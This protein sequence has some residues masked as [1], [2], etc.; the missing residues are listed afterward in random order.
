MLVLGIET[1]CD[2]TAASV[3]RNGNEIL[4]NVVSS[5]LKYHKKFGGVIPEIA[6]RH[7]AENIDKVILESLS[8]A[9]IGFKDIDAVSV[10]QG[11]GLSGALLIGIA[12]AKSIAYSCK[13]PLIAVGHSD[14]HIY[15][16]LIGIKRHSFPYIGLVISGGH[17]R[18]M[19]VQ[20][21]DKFKVLGDT[22][23]DAVGEAYDKV[24]KILGLEYPGGPIIDRLAKKGNPLAIKF[25]CRTV[26]N[27]FDFSF[28]GIKTAVLYY[29]TRH[30]THGTCGLNDIAASFQECALNVIVNTAIKA[31][32]Q[33]EI[34]T[35]LVGGGVSANSR[36]RE[37]LMVR[38]KFEKFKVHFPEPSLCTDNAVMVAG[39]GYRL[40][41]KGYRARLDMTAKV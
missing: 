8:R 40:F 41:R 11:T 15:S 17:T 33:Y 20:G 4:S 12:C 7:H 6:V 27:G 10:T 21:Y 36:L 37:K 5:S 30:T 24:A 23:D 1:S 35:L 38:S 16:S 32:K 9:D 31:M 25:T 3:V 2:E 29:V 26:N 14:A 34:N 13:I 39:L 28:S 19:I 22:L 18:L